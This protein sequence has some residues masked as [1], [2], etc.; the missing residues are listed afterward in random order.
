M[1]NSV[2]D[3]SARL[4]KSAERLLTTMSQLQ[5]ELAEVRTSKDRALDSLH[6]K[7]ASS[8]LVEQQRRE[9]E[10]SCA[11]LRSEKDKLLQQIAQ[12]QSESST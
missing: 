3:V 4:G 6:D 10:E 9:L 2:T 8:R 12:L 11:G 5:S 1:S 7:E